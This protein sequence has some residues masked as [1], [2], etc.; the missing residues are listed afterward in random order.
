MF[1]SACFD[2]R[3]QPIWAFEQ[4]VPINEKQCDSK[5][6]PFFSKVK[7][8]KKTLRVINNQSITLFCAL[9]DLM[10]IRCIFAM[11]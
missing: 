1:E 2:P 11:G 3:R 10:S 5:R 7:L 8:E 4:S 9:I 6:T